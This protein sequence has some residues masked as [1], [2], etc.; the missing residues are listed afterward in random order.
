MMDRPAIPT[1]DGLTQRRYHYWTGKSGRSY[2]HGVF[3]P[4]ELPHFENSALVI[5]ANDH[6]RRTI[7]DVAASGDLAELYFNGQDYSR[8]LRC[9]ANEVHVHFAETAGSARYISEDIAAHQTSART[10]M[11]EDECADEFA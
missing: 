10:C 6:G 9:G 8:A 7:I 11:L 2:L 1:I 3:A 5:I 4:A